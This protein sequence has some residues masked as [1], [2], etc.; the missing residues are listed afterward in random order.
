MLPLATLIAGTTVSVV[1]SVKVLGVLY[2]VTS[3][4]YTVP[5]TLHQVTEAAAPVQRGP[6]SSMPVTQENDPHAPV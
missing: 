6:L 5:G 3:T 4:R 2:P 1:T